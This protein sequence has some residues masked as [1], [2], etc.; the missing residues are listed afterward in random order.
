MPFIPA[1]KIASFTDTRTE[2]EISAD[3]A[4]MV[5]PT[6]APAAPAASTIEHT[7]KSEDVAREV[8]RELISTGFEVSLLSFDGSRGLYVF[9]VLAPAADLAL[10]CAPDCATCEKGLYLDRVIEIA[11]NHFVIGGVSLPGDNY[12]NATA[13]ALKM[14]PILEP[15][16]TLPDFVPAVRDV[17]SSVH[18]QSQ[19]PAARIPSAPVVVE[20][21]PWESVEE[22][23]DDGTRNWIV[24]D[25]DGDMVN[26]FL[27]DSEDDALSNLVGVLAGGLFV[28]T[29]ETRVARLKAHG[30]S[31]RIEE[32]VEAVAYAEAIL[33]ETP[34]YGPTFTTSDDV[35]LTWVDDMAGG[36]GYAETETV[37]P[38]RPIPVFNI[39]H[40][41]GGA[42]GTVYGV[43]DEH[44]AIAVFMA[45]E[46]NE[47]FA[48]EEIFAER[49]MRP[50]YRVPVEFGG[51]KGAA[52]VEINPPAIV[53]PLTL[54][55]RDMNEATS[56][57]NN[58]RTVY[59][60][61]SPNGPSF[62]SEANARDAVDL[63]AATGATV[64][65]WE[66]GDYAE[67]DLD[68]ENK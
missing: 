35:T 29:V 52:A 15:V 32:E 55:P 10:S 6:E 68:D 49:A 38:F 20:A 64:L 12:A 66:T 28:E 48:G 46:G 50:A 22:V 24:T 19:Y 42:I 54:N 47:V 30:Y 62:F 7:F 51:T 36:S 3:Y 56:F 63:A 41:T 8:R 40:K 21:T 37:D 25:K 2:A 31:A 60:V 61:H 65:D 17:V 9:D 34:I 67:I 43:S 53:D 26:H 4:K 23:E 27:A 59:V 11:G 39:E 18:A 1:Q 14:R 5:S 58:G 13:Y 44:A 33:A 45:R 16:I 57:V